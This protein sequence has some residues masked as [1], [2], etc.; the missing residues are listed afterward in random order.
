MGEQELRAADAA[1]YAALRTAIAGDPSAMDAVWAHGP[2]VVSMHPLGDRQVGWDAVRAAWQGVAQIGQ[3]VDIDL[4]DVATSTVGDVGIVTG[5]ERGNL[6]LWGR[7]LDYSARV[8]NVFR[9]E[10]GRWL[11]IVHHV[12]ASPDLI[13]LLTPPAVAAA[14]AR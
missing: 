3:Q 1:F 12:D 8:T 10:G 2:D 4:Q 13:R 6:D 14:G 5:T 11:L 7:H 9:R